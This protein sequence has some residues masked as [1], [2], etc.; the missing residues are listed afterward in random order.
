MFHDISSTMFLSLSLSLSLSLYG[1][2]S[3]VPKYRKVAEQMKPRRQERARS[4]EII[5]RTH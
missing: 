1:R 3:M 5:E 4:P 2:T